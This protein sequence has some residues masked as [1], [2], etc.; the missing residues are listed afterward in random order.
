MDPVAAVRSF[1]RFYTRH[2]GILREGLLNSPYSLTQVRVLYEL[3]HREGPSASEL[4]Q[5]LGLDP[6]YLSRL[7]GAFGKQGLLRKVACARDGRQILLHL[8]SAGHRLFEKLDARQN[9]EVMAMLQPLSWS[10]R[11]QL[12]RALAEV[13][14]ALEPQSTDCSSDSIYTLRSFRPGDIGWVIHRHGVLYAAEQHYDEHF[15]ALVANIA[16]EFINNYDPRRERCWM[17]EKDGRIAGCVFLVKKSQSVSK[18]RLLLVEPWARGL[19]IGKHLVAVCVQFARQAGY[20]KIMLWTQSDLPTARHLYREA[21]FQLQEQTP[22]H[23][24]G[25]NLV[26]ETWELRLTRPQKTGAP[27]LRGKGKKAAGRRSQLPI[28]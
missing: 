28:F 10:R 18:L 26:A 9:A 4:C 17:A 6:G 21:G 14:E 15:E 22:H 20:K 2:M 1:N 24:W 8:S 19:G 12:H 7:L 13:R 23:S 25:R 16:A 11:N 3:A 27:L 5:D